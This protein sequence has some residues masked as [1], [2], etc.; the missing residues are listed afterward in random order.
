MPKLPTLGYKRYPLPC[1]PPRKGVKPASGG[2][3]AKPDLSVGG[4]KDTTLGYVADEL[5]RLEN[6]LDTTNQAT[7]TVNDGVIEVKQTVTDMAA[8]VAGNTASITSEAT[9]RATADTALAT[10][11]TALTAT[12]AAGD[13]TNTASIISEATARAT[14]DTAVASSITTLTATVTTKNTTFTQDDAPTVDDDSIVTGDLWVDSNDNNKLYRWDGTDWIDILDGRVTA[15]IADA[16]TAQGAADGK[17]DSFYQDEAP[18]SA[19]EGDIWFDTDDG[20]KIYTYRSGTWTVT[21]D[22]QIAQAISDASD[23]DAKADGKVTTFY[24]DDAPTAEGTGDLWVDTDDGN[25]LYRWDGTDWQ[26]IRDSGIAETAAEA[27]TIASNLTSEATARATADAATTKVVNAQRALFGAAVADTWVSGATYTGS[28][29]TDTPPAATGDEVVVSGIVYR[30]SATHTAA[31]ANKPANTDYWDAVDTVDAKVA[32]G[33]VT[34][35]AAHT[36]AGY[37]AASA[38]TALTTRVDNVDG[39]GANAGDIFNLNTSIALANTVIT[40]DRDNVSARFGITVPDNYD[41]AKTYAVGEYVVYNALL[42]ICTTIGTTGKIPSSQPLYWTPQATVAADVAAA[43]TAERTTRVSAEEAIAARTDVV[44]ARI[45]VPPTG[46]TNWD[47]TTQYAVGD[48]V[49]HNSGK[50]YRVT[51][52]P[53]VGTVPT[54]ASYWAEQSLLS[55]AVTTEQTARADADTAL[56]SDIT[57]LATTVGTNT[58][59]IVSEATARSTADTSLASD[60][61]TLTST[62]S[63]VSAAV[64]TEAS[65]R[66]TAD[67]TAANGIATLE[68]KYGVSLNANGYV[69][70]FSQNNDG[71]TGT[72]KILA[73]KFTIIDPAS[74]AGEAGTQVFD[75]DNGVVTMGEAHIGSLSIGTGKIKNNAVTESVVSRTAYSNTASSYPNVLAANSS[76]TVFDTVSI[77]YLS[78]STV[79][80]ESNIQWHIAGDAQG[81]FSGVFVSENSDMNMKILRRVYDSDDNLISGSTQ[82]GGV[83]GNKSLG[84]STPNNLFSALTSFTNTSAARMEFDLSIAAGA[85][86]DYGI[87]IFS[88]QLFVLETK[89]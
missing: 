37:A 43:I 8:T 5:Q 69:T 35:S 68:A 21:Q 28:V 40:T 81:T 31:T 82:I 26:T 23:A 1:V 33:V 72:F 76:Y 36:T 47:S 61:T 49:V 4:L 22:S 70:G 29:N 75:I 79:F 50:V 30:A 89:K 6:S 12:V 16:A 11:V 56:A 88:H 19:S 3:V 10:L 20:N 34:A 18:A 71:T 48:E 2:A 55:A 54:N 38:V 78:G 9:A 74:S 63:D 57:S 65:T 58:A 85:S 32:A 41:S 13:S 59:A 80:V 87:R 17:I 83:L 66:A 60:I 42:Y 64:T 53:F 86:D 62:V 67:T 84:T 46:G 52:T 39:D 7:G 14:A 45:G 15:A 51:A 77:P 44:S 73:D 27:V 25:K 24:A